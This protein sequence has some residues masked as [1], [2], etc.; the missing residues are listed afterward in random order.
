MPVFAAMGCFD[1]LGLWE[2]EVSVLV[3]A[4]AI[5]P[6][7]DGGG[8]QHA[9]VEMSSQAGFSRFKQCPTA[10]S[11][12]RLIQCAEIT[13]LGKVKSTFQAYSLVIRDCYCC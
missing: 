7:R 2:A 12:V 6:L 4:T 11:R 5:L 13:S 9:N 10:T 8:R 1:H 3:F